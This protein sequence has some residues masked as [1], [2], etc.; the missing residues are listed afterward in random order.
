MNPYEPPLLDVEFAVRDWLN[1]PADW[2]VMPAYQDLD[3][4]T[5]WQI[6]GAAGRFATT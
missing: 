3:S 2:S 6:V 5:Y 4:D 1:A